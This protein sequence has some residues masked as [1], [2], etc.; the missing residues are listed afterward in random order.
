MEKFNL[1]LILFF[2]MFMILS[3]CKTKD[4]NNSQSQP[5]YV[6]LETGVREMFS[7][8]SEV[9]KNRD[10][11]GLVNRFTTDGTLKT[12]N[13]PLVKGIGA[14]R[15]FYQGALQLEDFKLD[16]KVTKVD[17]SKA[18]DMAYALAEF[19]LSYQTPGGLIHDSGNTL[20][21]FK[22]VDDTWKIASENL[23]SGPIDNSK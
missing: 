9:F 19:S 16:L 10:L 23:S 5:D 8:S 20:I 4:E 3:S 15:K 21:V 1:R 18:G 6:K 14:I 2:L 12:P 13:N 7:Y 22:R 11:E 17:I